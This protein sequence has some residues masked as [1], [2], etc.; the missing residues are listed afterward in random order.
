MFL[1]LSVVLGAG[2]VCGGCPGPCLE[3]VMM[4]PFPGAQVRFLPVRWPLEQVWG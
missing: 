3:R 4:E 1:G 2:Q